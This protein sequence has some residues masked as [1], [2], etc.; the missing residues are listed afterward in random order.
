[1]APHFYL[2]GATHLS[3]FFILPF[4]FLLPFC[5]LLPFFFLLPVFLLPFSFL[6]FFYIS[7]FFLSFFLFSFFFLSIHVFLQSPFNSKLFATFVAFKLFHFPVCFHMSLYFPKFNTMFAFD[8]LLMVFFPVVVKR[9][10]RI[11]FFITF[12]AFL[13]C[14]GM[15][16]VQSFFR[17]ESFFFS[18]FCFDLL[19]ILSSFR[20]HFI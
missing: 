3:F 17:T 7:S 12:G 16:C 13:F 15:T 4:V 1:M 2:Q 11:N 5:F 9:C 14:I 8:N 10:Q 6:S 19:K 18:T 20:S